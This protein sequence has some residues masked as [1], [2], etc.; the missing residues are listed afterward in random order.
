VQREG[1]LVTDGIGGESQAFHPEREEFHDIQQTPDVYALEDRHDEILDAL[2]LPPLPARALHRHK[3]DIA[4]LLTRHCFFGY[5]LPDSIV[6]S[7]VFLRWVGFRPRARDVPRR[8]VITIITS[9]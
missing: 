8:Q 9:S 2:A 1:I 3:A 5:F 4:N 6:V 7:C